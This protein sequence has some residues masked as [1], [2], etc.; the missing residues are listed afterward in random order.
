[1]PVSADG[2]S[3][4]WLRARTTRRDA[5]HATAA[6]CRQSDVCCQARRQESR[7]ALHGHGVALDERL[8]G[9]PQ[10][11]AYFQSGRG[12]FAARGVS[13]L[14]TG[15]RLWRAEWHCTIGQLFVGKCPMRHG[16]GRESA[17]SSDQDTVYREPRTAAAI[18]HGIVDK[19]PARIGCRVQCVPLDQDPDEADRRYPSLLL[20][21]DF[22]ML[23]CTRQPPALCRQR[24][25]STHGVRA[26][27][28]V[29]R[30]LRTRLRYV[31]AAFE[32]HARALGA[33]KPCAA[34][35]MQARDSALTHRRERRNRQ[36]LTAMKRR[37]HHKAKRI[38]ICAMRMA[39]R[40]L[41][42]WR[43]SPA[44]VTSPAVPDDHCGPAASVPSWPER[45][46]RLVVPA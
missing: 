8:V 5:S 26:A 39:C 17:E 16:E 11:R 20:T 12:Y 13:C 30:R 21:W 25:T 35:F 3:Q 34:W 9:L 28:R 2:V 15:G 1:M 24:G 10:A 43:R 40:R 22:S 41:G 44:I 46:A 7:G 6:A 42:A 23:I 37:E 45:F 38:V 14:A 31:A 27:M 18:D 33:R 36:A 4:H 29:G 19:Q 32:W